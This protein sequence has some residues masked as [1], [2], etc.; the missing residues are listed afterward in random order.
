MYLTL[1]N[2]LNRIF[3]IWRK[4]LKY[5]NQSNKIFFIL[6]VL[7]TLKYIKLDLLHLKKGLKILKSVK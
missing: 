5:S 2:T 6:N 7:Y 1:S 4:V 3:N